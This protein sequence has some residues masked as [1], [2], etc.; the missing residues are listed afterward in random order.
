MR[1]ATNPYFMPK[2]N[3]KK[4]VVLLCLLLIFT[5]VLVTI[6]Q[7]RAAE[8]SP[9]LVGISSEC[10]GDGKCSLCEMIKVAVNFGVFLIGIVGAVA[11][12]FF[13]YGGFLMLISAGGE[14]IQKGKSILINS[15]IGVAIVL[16]A[17]V[18]VTFAIGAVTQKKYGTSGWTAWQNITCAPMPNS[19]SPR[20]SASPIP[21]APNPSPAP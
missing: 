16:L 19:T 18:I 21:P 8:E 11:L 15:T 4:Y 6:P 10:L 17:Y 3:Y 5:A 13:V 7:A 12:F 20:I 2:L 1:Q 14:K 9:I